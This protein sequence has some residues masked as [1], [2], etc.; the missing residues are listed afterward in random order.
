MTHIASPA[1]DADLQARFQAQRRAFAADSFPDAATRRD[2]LER[3]KRL[4]EE[5]EQRFAS[6]ICADFGNRSRHETMIAETFF[7]LAGISHTRRH[8]AG[9]MKKRRV[10]T[11][12]HSLP[13]R[14]WILPQ[15][16][17][18][19]GVVSPWNYP[20]QLALA[21]A[22]A[23]L[24]AGNRVMIKPSE[25]TPRLSQLLAEL[26]GAAFR[27]DE[28]TVLTGDAELGKAFVRL[29][30]DHL[31]FTGS[32]AVG[33]QVALAAAANLTPVTLELGGKSPAIVDDSADLADSAHKIAAGKLFN[34][35]QTCIAPDYVL[36]PAGKQQAFADAY[37]QAVGELYPT[38]E[39]N[40]DYTSIV[41]GRHH[42]RLQTL[43]D[44][45]R[46][47]GARVIEVNPGGEPQ[48]P[49]ARRMRPHLL[50][51]VDSAMAVMRE[52]IFGPLLPVV[53]YDTA[54]QALAF[55]NERPR[56]L[57]LYW[58]G[59]ERSRAEQVLRATISGGVT[60]NDVLLH[61]A[62]ENLPFGG[63]GDSGIGAYHGEWGFRLF[64]KEKPVFE[65]SR[66]ARTAMLRPPFGAK[67]S[68]VVKA[69]KRLL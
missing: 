57:A 5:N 41:N 45:A 32:T 60:I 54:A 31:F 6:A 63:V 28:C 18:V 1:P 51:Q 56:P 65:Q 19:V 64:S 8:L 50:L 35:G 24:A 30:F 26:V 59:R 3:I 29:P 52:E 9:W 67:A 22:V 11:S 36:V 55:V 10:G 16:L 40:P 23:A 43:I 47:A 37:A 46:A 4:V 39:R 66:L 33:R 34:A 17:G 53:P 21:P 2:R 38:L 68:S 25:I 7:V 61:I 42:A 69:L 44:D 27:P 14:S 49:A 58:F 62:Q 20:L 12:F 48:E 15:P 13:G